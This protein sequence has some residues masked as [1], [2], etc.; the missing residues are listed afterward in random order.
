MTTTLPRP[1]K[2][3]LALVATCVAWLALAPSAQAA[4][5]VANYAV[6]ATIDAD[7]TLHVQATMTFDQAPASL[8]QTM[9]TRY[10]TTDDHEYRFAI[11]DV[12]VTSGGSPV[13]AQVN[14]GSRALTVTIPTQGVTAPVVLSYVVKG[15]A[16]RT[17]DGDTEVVWDLLQGLSLPVTSFDAV[18]SIPAV[19]TMVDCASG[20]PTDPGAC[21]S[22][23]GGTHTSPQPIFH[24]E[25]LN[26]GDI[27]RATVRFPS[28][29]VASNEDLRQLWTLDRAFS[30]GPAELGTALALL[31]LGGLGLW[32]AHRR[33][34]RDPASATSPTQ[35]AEFHPTA[36]GRSEFRVLDAVR[37][38]HVGTVL[39]ER[40]DP[41]DVT[42]TLLDLAAR[43]HLRITELPRRN[44]HAATD[45]AFSR[46]AGTDALVG[47]EK[48]LLE[49][50]A[51]EGGPVVRVS[52]LAR[53]VAPVIPTV[54][55][56]LYDDVV[57]RG[58]FARRPDATRST[59]GRLGWIA[60]GVAVLALVLLAAFTSFGVVGLALLLLA[61]G[62]VF[63]AAEMPARTASGAALLS[64]LMVL[65]GAL[66]TQATDQLP[67]G[68]E[69]QE[70]S[71]ILPY[72]VVLGGRERWLEALVEADGDA[73]S[74]A[75]DLDWYHAP[76]GWH[77]KD[78][79][80]AL[81]NFIT[82]VQGRLFSR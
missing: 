22:Y 44:E 18:I 66:L 72:A 75:E 60:V 65:R 39:D 28:N 21:I 33:L 78:L 57:A 50:V 11:S 38:G 36:A 42:A 14:Q 73:A 46:L 9:V 81:E 32:L 58:W 3:L 35:I 13:A 56:E 30:A 6:E 74:D 25:A 15:A 80:V 41:I 54:Q 61:L 27:V 40:V 59:W 45:W 19:L 17:A 8:T 53:V 68:R 37:P 31:A 34:G 79:P 69:Y 10:R 49:A 71:E 55:S 12:T 23:S 48:T 2:L 63:V 5:S 52:D 62:V 43:G 47:Y 70:L 82:T 67:T 24:D 1:F 51:P 7:G 16:L 29:A 64:G 77:L 76:S 26:A 20:N 4:E